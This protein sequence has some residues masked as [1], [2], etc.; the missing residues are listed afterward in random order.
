MTANQLS[1]SHPP[2]FFV[3]FPFN[4]NKLPL[5][6]NCQG[7]ALFAGKSELKTMILEC[8]SHSHCRLDQKYINIEIVIYLQQKLRQ[9][10]LI[11]G[12]IEQSRLITILRRGTGW[13]ETFAVWYLKKKRPTTWPVTAF[14]SARQTPC[15][16]LRDGGLPEICFL[17]RPH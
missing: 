16:F 15:F 11:T 3:S 4:L 17:T 2:C 12:P 13:G 6:I 5:Y 14:I 10:R 8:S 9:T 1:T 7:L